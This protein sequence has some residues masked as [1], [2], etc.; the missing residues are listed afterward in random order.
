MSEPARSLPPESSGRP[1][2]GPL[3]D[4]LSAMKTHSPAEAPRRDPKAGHGAAE[5]AWAPRVVAPAGP[6][7]AAEPEDADI[8][9]LMAENLMLKAKLRLEAERQDELQAILAEEIRTLR[10]HIQDE[11]GS[12]DELRAEQAE[13]RAERE[14][15]KTERERAAAERSALVGERDALREERDLWRARTEALAQPLFQ[16]QKR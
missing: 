2:P 7:P 11:I 6:S 14:R 8:S 5:T 4:W 1:A 10:A 9:E 16:M 13:I 12:L 15:F 3:R